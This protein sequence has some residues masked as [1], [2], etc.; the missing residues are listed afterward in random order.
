M[1]ELEFARQK[2]P[3]VSQRGIGWCIPAAIEVVLHFFGTDTVTQEEMVYDYY[4][5]FGDGAFCTP[6]QQGIQFNST[7]KPS[8][9][10]ASRGLLLTQANFDVFAEIAKER[11][12]AA[13]KSFQFIHPPDANNFPG[14]M[15][16]SID[17]GHGFLMACI[18]P[19]GGCHILAVVGYDGDI[20]HAY[21]PATLITQSKTAADFLV[22]YDFLIIRRA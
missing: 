4:Q 1:P 12:A 13:H 22:N 14:H 15:K 8:I 20:I 2:F 5:K 18:L 16:S 9:I 11:S 19:G 6:Q 21:D 17:A 7:D 3:Q 10:E